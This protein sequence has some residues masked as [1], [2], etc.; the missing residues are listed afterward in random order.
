MNAKELANKLL[1]LENLPVYIENQEIL[2]VLHLIT[3]VKIEYERD[4]E[5]YFCHEDVFDECVNCNN[6][7]DGEINYDKPLRIILETDNGDIL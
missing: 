1:E 2:N 6:C 4:H 7:L 3:N 5:N